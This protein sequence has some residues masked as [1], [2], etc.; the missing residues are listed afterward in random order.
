[1]PL[2]LLLL[3]A[4]RPALL[5]SLGRPGFRYG[6][7]LGLLNGVGI[8]LQVSGLALTTPAISVFVTSLASAWVPLVAYFAFRVTAPLLTLGGLTIG[9]LGAAILGTQSDPAWGLGLGEWLT[10]ASSGVFAVLIVL[11]DR[12]GRRMSAGELTLGILAGTGLPA[13]FAAIAWTASDP[14]TTVWLKGIAVLLE[15]PRVQAASALSRSPRS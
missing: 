14:G 12:W 9:I 10:L 6:L 7:L 15:Q 4:W 11:I 3:L 1:M 2:S 13:L 5:R 8:V